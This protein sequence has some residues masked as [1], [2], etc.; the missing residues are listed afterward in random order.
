MKRRWRRTSE[1]STTS[2][3]S[4]GSGP[5][6]RFGAEPRQSVQFFAALIA[7][8]AGSAAG[9]AAPKRQPW[10]PPVPI[11][12]RVTL[13]GITPVDVVIHPYGLR[14]VTTIPGE[15]QPEADALKSVCKAV[16]K[17]APPAPEAGSCSIELKFA[18]SPDDY[19]PPGSKRRREEGIVLVD[20]DFRYDSAKHRDP[21]VVMS[22]GFSDL[23]NAALKLLR[24]ARI[25]V[26]GCVAGR[27]RRGM[28]FAINDDPPAP[29]AAKLPVAPDEIVHVT[30][31]LI[32]RSSD[33]A[34]KRE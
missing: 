27:A 30:A 25:V 31:F 9:A 23:D 5:E 22:S 24:S 26:Q 19:Y 33:P 10:E 17:V 29:D 12:C 4:L 34:I 20:F 21:V 16:P 6:D 15:S 1:R 11:Q 8:M 7:C 18:G 14:T 3:G 28:S 32:S 13:G 2:T